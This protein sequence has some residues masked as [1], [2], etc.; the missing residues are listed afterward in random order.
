MTPNKIDKKTILDLKGMKFFVPAY[1]RGYRWTETEVKALLEDI[2]EFDTQNEKFKYCLQ[3]LVV[4]FRDDG[5]NELVDG[6]QRLTT[7]F[8]FMKYVQEI[9]PKS[10]PIFSIEYETREDSSVFL[11]SLSP[12]NDANESNIDFHFM[13]CAYKA[14]QDWVAEKIEA[15]EG[16]ESTIIP[17][18]NNKIKNSVFFIWYELAKDSNPIEMFSKVN[19]GKIPLTNAELIK[20]LLLNS[21][22]FKRE[23]A[24][25]RQ[26]E[27]SVS[28]DKIEQELHHDSLWYFLNDF[29]ERAFGKTHIDMVF[30]LLAKEYNNSRKLGI[31][32]NEPLFSFLVFSSVLKQ[33]ADK[34]KAVE[35]IW[36]DTELKFEKMRFWYE[37]YNQ[38]HLIGY[39][40][41]QNS[42]NRNISYIQKLMSDKGK[43]QALK[44][45]RAEM[46]KDCPW[47]FCTS[48]NNDNDKQSETKEL[49][50]GKD[51]KKIR[52]VLLMFNIAMLICE[53]DRQTRFPFDIYKKGKWDI[54]HIHATADESD[55][56]D[57]T[58]SNLTLL[59]SHINQSYKDKPFD[60]KRN[61]IIKCEKKGDFIPLCTKNV[62]L[63]YFTGDIQ[64]TDSWDSNDKQDYIEAIMNTLKKFF[65]TDA[66][67][68]GK[69][70]ER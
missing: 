31:S 24:D 21:G 55:D 30:E 43:K 15:N 11:N 70:E 58:L 61:I 53:S 4:Q 39:L 3:P 67:I 52:Q 18:L 44:A 29:N 69:M 45:L 27:I 17:Q 37:D 59:N 12:D 8:I 33:A 57:D 7:I 51:N 14:M 54:E 47:D 9:M 2:W 65:T 36:R 22:N 50:Y 13:S 20:A 46:Q 42:Q 63:K 49:I 23:N 32:E 66:W 41:S 62:F 68:D 35:E 1:Q 6:Q 60:E 28:W 34:E 25:K 38:Y 16:D 48:A 19:I 40:L 5:K 10:E 56:P 26:T 64:S